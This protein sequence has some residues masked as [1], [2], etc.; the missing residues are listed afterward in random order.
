MGQI[1]RSRERILVKYDFAY[2]V[3]G[4]QLEPFYDESIHADVACVNKASDMNSDGDGVNIH[5]AIVSDLNDQMILAENIIITR[6]M[7]HSLR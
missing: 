4:V 2:N 3:G 7:L 6:L 5:C 1:P